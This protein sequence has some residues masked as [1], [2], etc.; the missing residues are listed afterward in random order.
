M[1][2]LNVLMA[3]ILLTPFIGAAQTTAPS[4][5]SK[6]NQAPRSFVVIDKNKDGHISREEA[7]QAGVS[8]FNFD[9]AD[10]DKDGRLNLS[11]WTLIK[12]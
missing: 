9:A 2:N 4:D 1:K 12:F 8:T 5:A 11:E 6:V 7:Q 10:K 3:A